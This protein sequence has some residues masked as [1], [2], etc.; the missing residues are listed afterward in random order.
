LEDRVK[1]VEKRFEGKEVECP[2]HW[3]GWRIVPL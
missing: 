1:D 2:E 3:G